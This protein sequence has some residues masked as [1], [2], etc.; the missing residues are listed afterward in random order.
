[1]R[2]RFV[3]LHFMSYRKAP[4]YGIRFGASFLPAPCTSSEK[5]IASGNG[6][7]CALVLIQQ[8]ITIIINSDK[9]PA[10]RTIRKIDGDMFANAAGRCPPAGDDGGYAPALIPFAQNLGRFTEEMGKQFLGLAR[11]TMFRQHRNGIKRIIRF[12][13]DIDTNADDDGAPAVRQKLGFH[14]NAAGLAAA[15]QHVIWPFDFKRLT[16]RRQN[17]ANGAIDRERKSERQGADALHRR[18]IDQKKGSVEIAGL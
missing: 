12:M 4:T 15:D 10:D 9:T 1:M 5:H 7:S 18:R 8:Q 11:R 6:A 17:R 13:G 16:A 3:T 14:Q 2:S